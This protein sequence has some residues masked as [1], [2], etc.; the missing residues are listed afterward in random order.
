MPIPT[1]KDIQGDFEAWAS[2]R[3]MANYKAI[4]VWAELILYKQNPTTQ[5]G[6]HS[7]IALLFPMEYLFED[8]VAFHLSRQLPKGWRLRAQVAQKN[9]VQ[10][11]RGRSMFRLKPDLLLE[12]LGGERIVLDTKWKLLNSTSVVEKYGI[13]QS[14]IYQMY[15]YGHKY[16]DGKGKVVLIYPKHEP[17][18][19][20]LQQFEFDG[21]MTLE[22]LPFDLSIQRLET[23]FRLFN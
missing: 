1:S 10:S 22:V 11:H 21:Q 23:K 2:D 3:L 13:S 16:L 14:D 17:F 20:P 18:N 15:A 4:R 8:Y 9:L 5:R 19:E 6:N 7:G 12:S